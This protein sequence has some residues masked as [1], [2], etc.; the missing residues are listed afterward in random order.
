MKSVHCKF[1]SLLVRRLF[2]LALTT[3]CCATMFGQTRHFISFDAP[4]AGTASFQGTIAVSI[5]S[6][7]VIAGY[8]FDSNNVQHGFVRQPNGQFTEFT[9]QG[10]QNLI[11][12]Q[13][14]DSGVVLGSGIP[15]GSHPVQVGFLRAANG[16]FT[17]IQLSGSIFTQPVALNGNNVV[18][19]YYQDSADAW[20]GFIRDAAGNYTVID[21]PDAA[22]GSQLGTFPTAINAT[23]VI[24][25]KYNDVNTGTERAFIRDQFGNFT[26]FDPVAGG[27]AFVAV[28]GIN[29][30]GQVAGLYTDINFERFSFL[31]DSSGTV[32]D[33]SF[34]G[35]TGNGTSASAMNDNGIIVGDW[36]NSQT[37]TRG[38]LRD[39]AGNLTSLNANQPNFET[40][41]LSINNT[42]RIAGT[43]DDPNNVDHGFV[44]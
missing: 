11:I 29:A 28:V 3:L 37:L 9:P 31:R 43:W 24:A 38:F 1:S 34:P 6:N 41:P 12:Y 27:S 32:T 33:F 2:T 22:I 23:G 18:T 16:Q 19:G 42:G 15:Q 20:H 39:A 4:G 14:N 5:N 10:F 13:I 8:Y 21:D 40:I 35:A 17:L 44:E 26:N 30:G 7:G 36:E 25:G